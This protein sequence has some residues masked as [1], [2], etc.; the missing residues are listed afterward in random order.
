MAGRL[1]RAWPKSSISSRRPWPK[2]LL[3]PGAPEGIAQAP[4]KRARVAA[5]A[6]R[7][8]AS[9]SG[10]VDEQPLEAQEGAGP[11]AALPTATPEDLE[12]GTE[13][14]Y[15]DGSLGRVREAFRPL[16]LFWVED[17]LTGELVRDLYDAVVQ[18]RAAEL[19]LAGPAPAEEDH[20]SAGS[21]PAEGMDGSG[22]CLPMGPTSAL[23]AEGHEHRA[24]GGVMLIG[25]QKQML[26]I[27]QHH[28]PPD[29]G[30]Q[31]GPLQLLAIPCRQC[32][33]HLLL[34]AASKGVADAIWQLAGVSRRAP[35]S[36]LRTLR[37]Q[38]VV[39]QLGPDFLQLKDCF[40]LAAVQLQDSPRS[41]R[42]LDLCISATGAYPSEASPEAAARRA[43]SE[44]CRI[45]ASDLLWDQQV[46]LGLRQHLGA[47]IALQ[48]EDEDG[49]S[50]TVLILP[51]DAGMLKFRGVLCFS[52]IPGSEEVSKE[53]PTPGRRAEEVGKEKPTPGTRAEEPMSSAAGSRT[54]EGAQTTPASTSTTACPA[55]EEGQGPRKTIAHWESEQAQFAGEAELPPGWLRVKSRTGEVYY[56]NKHTQESTFTF[57][58]PPLPEG[59]L[60]RVSRTTGRTYY[61]H[62]A[63]GVSTFQRP[64]A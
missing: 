59:W 44:S 7:A 58:E 19:L 36:A 40:C 39:E 33:P 6:G 2:A 25:S 4:R 37:F 15:W 57:P 22:D 43:L 62:A 47:D 32:A 18:F 27:L 38:Q 56:F 49:V 14:R 9:G 35:G 17:D 53:K 1:A 42:Q 5:G 51:R 28:G 12:P 26:E 20:G 45:D 63:A 21:G 13:V 50:V 64:R 11:E 41:R 52:E 16:D 3:K 60:E 30:R 10:E 55:S 24:V 34:S 61:V 54:S 8:A 31:Q 23:Q 29:A 46:Q 48:L